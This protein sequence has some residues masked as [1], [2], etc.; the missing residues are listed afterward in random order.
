M[1]R[2]KDIVTI[3]GPAG[4][5]KSTVSRELAKRLGYTFLDTGAMYRAVA[6]A[7]LEKGIDLADSKG[8]EELCKGLELKIEASGI[9]VNSRDVSSLIRTPEIDRAASDVSRT[10]VVRDFLGKLQRQIGQKGKIVAE[11]RD[12][13]TVVFPDARYKFF[14]TATPEERARRRQKQLEEQG[15][16]VVYHNILMQIIS[17]DEADASRSLA[18]LKPAVD[19]EIIDS[20][21]LGLEEVI[22]RM[23]KKLKIQRWNY[24]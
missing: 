23:I 6:W 21:N 12:M 10:P 8:L 14:L 7:A 19:A 1:D 11:G 5:G 13:G 16:N 20:S 24:E 22:Q 18:P 4:A 15:K 9:Y 17:R 2:K 3:D